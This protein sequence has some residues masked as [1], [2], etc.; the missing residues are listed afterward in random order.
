ME[1]KFIHLIRIHMSMAIKFKNLLDDVLSQFPNVGKRAKQDPFAEPFKGK[2]NTMT[3]YYQ[4][5]KKDGSDHVIEYEDEEST[6]YAF[7]TLLG[8]SIKL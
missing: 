2:K 5:L 3:N 4:Q 7:D 8:R 1:L 6:Y